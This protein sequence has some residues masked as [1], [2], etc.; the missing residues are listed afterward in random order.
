MKRIIIA[1]FLLLPPVASAGG[2]E[3]T[4]SKLTLQAAQGDK[5]FSEITVGNPTSD[6][7]IFEVYA[8]NF[9]DQIQIDPASFILEAKS[10]KTLTVRFLGFRSGVFATNLSVLAKP[11]L[12][13]RFSANAG[14]KIPVSATIS[15][16][17]TSR[18]DWLLSLAAIGGILLLLYLGQRRLTL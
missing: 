3:V 11:L 9:S 7:Q 14:V 15:S 10:R 18:K 17:K 1:L 6:V 5:L 4:P 8:D 16:Q 13:S 12:D 2:L